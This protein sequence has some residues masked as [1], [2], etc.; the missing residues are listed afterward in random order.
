M[1]KLFTLSLLFIASAA[2]A[3][4][5]TR[6]QLIYRAP[7]VRVIDLLQQ[8][9]PILEIVSEVDYLPIS[10]IGIS[11]PSKPLEYH[12]TNATCEDWPFINVTDYGCI[13][14]SGWIF[15]I[16]VQKSYEKI[17]VS[18]Q[19]YGSPEQLISRTVEVAQVIPEPATIFSILIGLGLM[20][21]FR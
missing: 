20:R 7:D 18:I 15:G 5:L 17:P 9:N 10:I 4:E 6:L 12:L 13:V 21:R 14:E 16:K 2:S 11:Q 1:R 8:Y 3:T 19:V